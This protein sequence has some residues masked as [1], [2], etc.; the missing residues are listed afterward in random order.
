[1]Q[2]SSASQARF[3]GIVL[4][5]SSLLSV[6]AM[7]HHP[8]V[9]APDMATALQA[10]KEM[11]ALSGWVHGILIALMLVTLWALTEFCRQRGFERPLVRAGLVF[12]CA[13]VFSMIVAA[14]VSGWITPAVA[15][16]V[17]APTDQDLHTLDLLLHFGGMVNRSMADIGAVAMSAGIFFWSLGLVHDTGA[18]RLTGALG[19]LVGLAPAL[20]LI[21]GAFHLNV[22]GMLAVVLAQ[23]LW[24]LAVGALLISGKAA[25]Q[26]T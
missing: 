17:P 8:S 13:G 24:T 18:A 2:D 23:G 20:G 3:G 5:V 4:V 12:Y 21:V 6:L 1:M 9:S 15:A 7:A 19:I 26:S 14:A 10:I 25:P 11:T 22:P 16:F